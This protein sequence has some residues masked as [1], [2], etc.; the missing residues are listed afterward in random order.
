M[1]SDLI[2]AES[3]SQLYRNS[4]Y[5]KRIMGGLDSMERGTVEWNS[6]LVERW[7]SQMV[8]VT[9]LLKELAVK[10]VV[11]GLYMLTSKGF[12]TSLNNEG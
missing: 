1:I 4:Q 12:S 9:S 8:G 11:L 7:N 3:G 10:C 2:F 6:G 5:I